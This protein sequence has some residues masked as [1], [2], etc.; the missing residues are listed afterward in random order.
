MI[1]MYLDSL[2]VFSTEC[3]LFKV[4]PAV[5]QYGT[6]APTPTKA[7]PPFVVNKGP[8]PLVSLIPS[9]VIPGLQPPK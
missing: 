6:T 3:H 7:S 9:L 4:P 5:S 2:D 8:L 1:L